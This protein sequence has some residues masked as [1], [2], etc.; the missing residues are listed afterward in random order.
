MSQLIHHVLLIK[1]FSASSSNNIIHDE[2]SG[3]P[4]SKNGKSRRRGLRGYL[5]RSKKSARCAPLEESV[6]KKEDRDT[7]ADYSDIIPPPTIPEVL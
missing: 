5:L 7:V 1:D 4:R 3:T 2:D 6:N